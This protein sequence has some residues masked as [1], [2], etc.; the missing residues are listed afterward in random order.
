MVDIKKGETYTASMVRKGEGTNG[1]W[2]LLKIKN[3]RDYMNIWPQ[4]GQTG[5]EEGGTFRIV[6]VESVKLSKRE[7]RGEW[8]S[9]VNVN[10]KVEKCMNYEEYTGD[11]GDDPF[12][13]MGASDE[14]P[15]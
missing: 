9:E 3:G 8:I 2:E 13:G 12:S 14:L 7:Y 10:A 1:A 5:V 11:Y 6:E 4:G 15:L